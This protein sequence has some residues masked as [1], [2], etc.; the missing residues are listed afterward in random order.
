V[1][2]PQGRKY[3]IYD[4]KSQR[5]RILQVRSSSLTTDKLI[6]R[7]MPTIKSS[8]PEKHRL[9]PSQLLQSFTQ[10]TNNSSQSFQFLI[11]TVQLMGRLDTFT[12]INSE[13]LLDFFHL[14]KI[15]YSKIINTPFK[16]IK[17]KTISHN[18]VRKMDSI[19][20]P[21]NHV[22][23]EIYIYIQNHEPSR[24]SVNE[25]VC[26]DVQSQV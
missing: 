8:I 5:Y 2:S 14:S 26:N 20:I 19:F 13:H 4:G 16:M 7:V 9:H 24:F 18:L 25:N 23:V 1:W 21:V 11:L 10:Q 6:E 22:V 12:L 17:I 15:K 3:N